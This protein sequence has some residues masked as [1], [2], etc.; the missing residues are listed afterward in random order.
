MSLSERNEM[1][2]SMFNIGFRQK[3]LAHQFGIGERHV[4]R[5]IAKVRAK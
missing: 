4:K 1:I 5:I 2:V 3:V